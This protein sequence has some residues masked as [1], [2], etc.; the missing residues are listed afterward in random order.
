[1]LGC[2]AGGGWIVQWRGDVVVFSGVLVV[3]LC[4]F[5]LLRVRGGGRYGKGF[6]ICLAQWILKSTGIISIEVIF[7]YIHYTLVGVQKITEKI[8]PD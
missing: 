6:E 1:V 7:K 5:L 8:G 3:F 4:L 2:A